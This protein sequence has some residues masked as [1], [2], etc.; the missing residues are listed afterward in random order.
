M[1]DEQEFKKL[2]DEA[3]TSLSRDLI[4][5]SEDYE[6]EVDFN[7]G[8]LG[9]EFEDPPAKFVISPNTPVRQIW[10]SANNKSYKLD[11]DVV[12]NSFVHT[13]SGDTLKNLVEKAVSKHLG[14]E[15]SL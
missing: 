1:L 6:Y 11:W 3:L 14:E 2:A 13:E 4:A 5:A 15:F 9:V 8:A 10:V 7:A 12:E